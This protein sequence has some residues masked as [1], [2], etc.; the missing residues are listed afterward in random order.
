[1]NIDHN[2]AEC[3]W[4]FVSYPRASE[5]L[6]DSL[7]RCSGCRNYANKCIYI[8]KE[9]SSA[10]GRGQSEALMAESRPKKCSCI[11]R[12][13]AF[14]LVLHL[15]PLLWLTVATWS[16]NGTVLRYIIYICVCVCVFFYIEVYIS[17]N[18]TGKAIKQMCSP[19]QTY[20]T[21]RPQQN[22][23]TLAH[24][25]TFLMLGLTAEIQKALLYY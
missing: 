14:F 15:N 2:S 21:T 23:H 5:K 4:V 8:I 25:I 6:D 11:P 1:M 20:R 24:R 10:T 9:A 17:K 22:S 13:A 18:D 3:T 19:S 7:T 12:L 16:S